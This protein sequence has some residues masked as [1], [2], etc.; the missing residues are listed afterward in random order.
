MNEFLSI[1]KITKHKIFWQNQQDPLVL[2]NTTLVPL[3]EYV[4]DLWGF[5]EKIE[6]NFCH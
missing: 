2:W 1:C 4:H 5:D 3:S 6:M